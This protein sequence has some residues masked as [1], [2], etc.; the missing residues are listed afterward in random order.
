[1]ST[2]VKHRR[3]DGQSTDGKSLVSLRRS[4]IAFNAQFIRFNNLSDFTRASVYID[5]ERRRLG[6]AFHSDTSD[7]DSFAMTPDGGKKAGVSRAIQIQ[8]VMSKNRWLRAASELKDGRARQY[9]PSKH[10]DGKWVISIRPAF[11]V[12]SIRDNA[13]QIP[14]DLTGIYRYLF[15]GENVYIERGVIRSC[16]ASPERSDWIFNRVEFSPIEEQGEQ[17]QLES[18]WIEEY[19]SANGF[20]PMYNRI[21]GRRSK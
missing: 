18:E 9:S 7:R 1:M 3:D 19:R 17:E 20:L 21:G 4:A 11:E 13:S 10:P 12:S 15:K 8:S 5:A 6:F 2:W 16:I 14:D